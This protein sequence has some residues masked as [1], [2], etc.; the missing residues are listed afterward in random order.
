VNWQMWEDWQFKVNARILRP[1]K[2]PPAD[3]TSTTRTSYRLIFISLSLE[4][5][6]VVLIT[7]WTSDIPVTSLHADMF[8]VP[9]YS[10]CY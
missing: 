9:S 10:S 3:G 4:F 2:P 8:S 6:L 7:K 5:R 1:K